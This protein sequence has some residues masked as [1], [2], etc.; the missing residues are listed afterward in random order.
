MLFAILAL[1]LLVQ[2]PPRAQTV[3]RDSTPADSAR[4]NA[5]TRLP[6]TAEVLASAFRDAAARELFDQARRTRIAHDSSL[7]SYDAKTRQRMSVWGSIGKLGFERLV[8]RNE[9]V[10][11]V[12]WKRGVGA[13]V[14]VT[15]ARVAIPVMGSEKLER[16]ALN[17]AASDAMSPIP[18]FPGSE[19]LWAGGLPAQTEVNDRDLV[20][21]LAVGAEA[22]YTYRTGDSVTF[23]LPDG[24]AIRLRELEVRP[25]AAKPNFAVGSLWFDTQTGQLVRAAY[26]LAAPAGANISVSEDD[27]TQTRTQKVI[28]AIMTGMLSPSEAKISAVAIEYGLFGG[29]FWLP[30]LQF[31]EGSAQASF[32]V[33]RIRYEN[34]FIY[35]SVNGPLELS[36]FQVDTMLDRWPR[37]GR[38]PRG[39]DSAGRKQ[40]RDSVRVVYD[41]ALAAR[42]DSVK[43]KLKTGSYQQCDSSATRVVTQYRYGDARLPVQVRVPCDLD[44]LVQSADFEKSIYDPDDEV[45]GTSDRERLVGEALTML[46]QAPLFSLL[47]PPRFQFGPSMTRYNR[48]E[49]FSTGLRVDQEI[50]GGYSVAALGRFGFADRIPNWEFSVARSNLSKTVRLNG[51]QRLVSASDWGNPLSFGSG[52]SALLFGRDEGFYY[53]AGGAELLWTSDRGPRLNW[54]AFAER[55]RTATPEA[56]RT[57]GGRFGPNIVATGETSAGAS[58]RFIHTLGQ[59]PRSFRLFTDLRL[60]GAGGDSTYGRGALDLTLSRE[61]AARF[62]AALSVAGGTSVGGIPTQR[63]WFLGGTQTIRG[64]TPDTAQSGNAFWFGRLELARPMPGVRASLFGDIGWTGDRT[65]MD[66]IGRPLS[67]VGIGLSGFDGLIRFDVARGLYPS[68]QTRVNL[69]LDARF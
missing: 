56:T 19:T 43:R 62:A 39:L 34:S 36:A 61:L 11:R 9:S 24:R 7:S 30:R 59:N 6:V 33:V 23:R 8:F 5:P 60:E 22:Y 21:P 2:N 51:Y 25:R 53:R 65:K 26:R 38:P 14:E 15:G 68:K 3:V 48:V 13:H 37:L 40:W 63:G 18:Y 12:Q 47:P 69:Y 49:G 17:D 42:Q 44:Q 58:I 50:G 55:Q 20:N 28:S 46:A 31:V 4:R 45:F 1:P 52:V 54:R 32:A 67:G 10:A 57:V 41:S 27:T 29:R 64:Q 66:A 16:E 35:A